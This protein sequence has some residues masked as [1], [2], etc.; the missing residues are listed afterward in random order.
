M[1]SSILVPIDLGHESSWK[2]TLPV[3]VDLATKGNGELHILV[4][5]PDYG[6]PVVGSYFPDDFSRNA[7]AETEKALEKFVAEHVP[8]GMK[9]SGHVRHGTIYKEIIRA[10]TKLSCSLIVLSSHRPET[11]DYL[12]GPNAS[13]VVRHANQSVFV[14]RDN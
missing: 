13:R 4:V 1:Y 9:V 8:A 6:L 7:T 11:K 12:L 2:K 10:A 5:I 3:A 14:V